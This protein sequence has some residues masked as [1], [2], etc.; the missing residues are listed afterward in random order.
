MLDQSEDLEA[1]RRWYGGSDRAAPS[2]NRLQ[3]VKANSIAK[4]RDLGEV[5]FL[6]LEVSGELGSQVGSNTVYIKCRTSQLS[7]LGLRSLNLNKY[8]NKYISLGILGSDRKPLQRSDEGFALSTESLD[9]DS[10]L[11]QGIERQAQ[12][13]PQGEFFFT[14]SSS[15]FSAIPYEVELIVEPQ[16]YLAG[17]ALGTLTASSRIALVKLTGL[18][19]A[20]Q[21]AEGTLQPVELIVRLAGVASGA[22]TAEVTMFVP[23]GSAFCQDLTA[24]RLQMNYR[25]AGVASGSALP[26]ATAAPIRRMEGRSTCNSL[27]LGELSIPA[28]GYGA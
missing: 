27:N 20:A 25:A 10:L 2:L 22:N 4:A 3:Y 14:I 16:G 24:G 12:F 21:L 1:R 13:F 23:R 19:S 15:S 7:R 17:V 9:N 6:A 28:G 11:P 18:A 26:A 5:L 8:E